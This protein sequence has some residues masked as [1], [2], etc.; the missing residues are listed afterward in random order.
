M[1]FLLV[2]GFVALAAAGSMRPMSDSVD[3]YILDLIDN[4][5]E[6]EV[7]VS[8]EDGGIMQPAPQF[9]LSWQVRRMIRKMQKQMPCGWPQYGIPP[10]APLRVTEAEFSL[11]RGILE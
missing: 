3:E 4:N 8:N 9:I 11:K 1:R 10:L 5:G 7:V 2:L 6:L